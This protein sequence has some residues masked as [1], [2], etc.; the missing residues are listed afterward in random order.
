MKIAYLL[1]GGQLVAPFAQVHEQYSFRSKSLGFLVE[2][3]NRDE[4]FL[5]NSA[6]DL[7]EFLEHRKKI[8]SRRRDKYPMYF[9]EKSTFSASAY[10]RSHHLRTT[11][12][13]KETIRNAFSGANSSNLISV[14][15]T[16][17]IRK[18]SDF[19]QR[20]L[21]DDDFGAT[22]T[23]YEVSTIEPKPQEVV[24]F[25][26][27][28]SRIFV[29]HYTSVTDA[30][31]MTGVYNDPLIEDFDHFPFYDAQLNLH[32]FD[33]LGLRLVLE[34]PDFHAPIISIVNSN[35]FREFERFRKL[36]IE[37]IQNTLRR[38]SIAAVRERANYLGFIK[39]IPYRLESSVEAS[40]VTA[41]TLTSRI[42]ELIA[43]TSE[44][45]SEFSEEYMKLDSITQGFVRPIAIFTATD[46]EDEVLREYLAL[47]RY[48]YDDIHVIEEVAATK[49]DREGFASIFHVRT[50]AGSSGL[51]GSQRLS[52]A[53][54][55]KLKPERAIAVGIC[56]G[57]DITKQSFGDVVVSERIALYEPAAIRGGKYQPRGDKIPTDSVLIGVAR[58]C[59][60]VMRDFGIH[61]GPILSG[62]KLV[63]DPAF[64]DTLLEFEE[65]AAGGEMEAAGLA[66]SC[67][68]VGT[69]LTIVKG[70]ADFA[71]NKN[72][73]IQRNAAENA[74]SLTFKMIEILSRR[75][76]R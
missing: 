29:N 46:L 51:S 72:D 25:G 58:A 75:R 11:H 65:K 39:S 49:Y 34:D 19:I 12:H 67:H 3:C 50:S 43:A 24:F 4:A 21:D 38:R 69:P 66:I 7:Y 41:S 44:F 14:E 8:Y 42:R 5:Y 40:N 76:N 68:A 13:I 52:E 32:I 31:S 48:I 6:S 71:E 9:G 62:D 26:D 23:V 54:L 70:I 37:A 61:V 20:S 16:V 33:R 10:A 30:I 36:Y 47:N 74:A 64:R 2:L 18:Q 22:F 15:D 57:S 27:V 53:I 17:R 55:V 63:D 45:E 60:A 59:R 28:S 56:F 73:K 35:E 1:S